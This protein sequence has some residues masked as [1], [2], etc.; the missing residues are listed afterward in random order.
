MSFPQVTGKNPSTWIEKCQDYFKILDIPKGM[1][2]WSTFVQAVESKFGTNDYKEALA[3]ILEC[4]LRAEEARDSEGKEK[5]GAR[6]SAGG[7]CDEREAGRVGLL[8]GSR[9]RHSEL[10][11]RVSSRFTRLGSRAHGV[12]W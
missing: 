2:E 6:G 9:R 5:I 11:V 1:G 8:Q 3:Q 7:G 12:S 10:S 4:D